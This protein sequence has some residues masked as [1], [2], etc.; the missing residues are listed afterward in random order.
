MPPAG[1]FEA[2]KTNIIMDNREKEHYDL[3]ETVYLPQS[4][5]YV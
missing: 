3:V 4:F 2:I 5:V 1:L